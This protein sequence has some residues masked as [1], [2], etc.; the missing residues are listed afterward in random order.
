MHGKVYENI[1]ET[2]G[3]TPLVRLSKLSAGC[4]AQVAVKLESFNPM[5]S[6]KDRMALAMI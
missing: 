6:I 2:I 5:S 3:N 1:A 4:V